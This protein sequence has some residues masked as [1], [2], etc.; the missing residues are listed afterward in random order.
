MVGSLVDFKKWSV[1][2]TLKDFKNRQIYFHQWQNIIFNRK[3]FPMAFA[4]MKITSCERSRLGNHLAYSFRK[5]FVE[6]ELRSFFVHG[7][8]SLFFNA[9]NWPF[10]IKFGLELKQ[11]ECCMLV[12]DVS[13]ASSKVDIDL[14][15]TLTASE[16][17]HNAIYIFA[18]VRLILAQ[19]DPFLIPRQAEGILLEANLHFIH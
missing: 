12:H 15:P 7:A 19:A 10:K 8:S 18:I 17:C 11:L 6:S 3:G 1:G 5:C 4:S 9:I 16:K 14:Y 2:G 13:K